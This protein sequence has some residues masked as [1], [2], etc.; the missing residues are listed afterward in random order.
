[1]FFQNLSIKKKC[2]MSIYKMIKTPELTVLTKQLGVMAI[3]RRIHMIPLKC[4]GFDG[5]LLLI[6]HIID[7]P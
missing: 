3:M 7:G 1:M 2:K 5:Y 4:R 6:S